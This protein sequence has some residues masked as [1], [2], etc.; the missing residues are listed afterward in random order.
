MD[1]KNGNHP[2]ILTSWTSKKNG[3]FGEQVLALI[4]ERSFFAGPEKR[5]G[6]FPAFTQRNIQSKESMIL[7][8]K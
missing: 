8:A 6:D 1:T 7:N 4:T 5:A 3:V 2:Q